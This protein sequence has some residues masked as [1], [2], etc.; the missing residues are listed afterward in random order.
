MSSTKIKQLVFIIFFIVIN[1]VI[2][3]SITYSLGVTN[4]VIYRSVTSMISELTYEMLI[5][6]SLAF[7]E[8]SIY[9]ILQIKY[10][11]KKLIN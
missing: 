5:F 4:T 7:I 11:Q 6:M 1:L 9:E 8:S 10:T 2:S 3:F